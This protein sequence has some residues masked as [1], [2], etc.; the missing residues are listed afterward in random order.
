MQHTLEKNTQN[1]LIN[2]CDEEILVILIKKVYQSCWFSI[3]FYETTDAAHKEQMS[4]SLRYVHN[5]T[6]REDFI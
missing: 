1:E 3:I 2:V 6:I 4:I 5:K